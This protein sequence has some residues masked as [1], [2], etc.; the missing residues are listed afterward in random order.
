MRVGVMLWVIGV[1]VGGE[2]RMYGRIAA[3]TVK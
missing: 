2:V 1:G 3:C